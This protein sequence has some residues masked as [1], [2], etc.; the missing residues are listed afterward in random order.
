LEIFFQYNRVDTGKRIAFLR[1]N[2]GL[3]R[4]ALAELLRVDQST[5]AYWE[6]GETEPH[7]RT[8]NALLALFGLTIAE[9]YAL[10]ISKRAA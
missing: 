5:V 4:T 8:R 3:S 10:K 2:M 1:K 9:F 7:Q 6:R